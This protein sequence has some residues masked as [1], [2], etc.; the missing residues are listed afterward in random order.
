[1]SELDRTAINYDTGFTV[2]SIATGAEGLKI[3]NSMIKEL[4]EKEKLNRDIAPIIFEHQD[5]FLDLIISK[6]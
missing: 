4:Q 2:G 1:M 5:K 3:F 6:S